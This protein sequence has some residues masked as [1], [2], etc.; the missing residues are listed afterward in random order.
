MTPPASLPLRHRESRVLALGLAA[1][2]LLVPA[3]VLPVLHTRIAGEV[4]TDTIYSGVLELWHTGLWPIAALVFI[5]SFLVPFAKLAGLAWLLLAAR[6]GPRNPRRLTQL[7]ALLDF[8]GRWSMLDV[9][10]AAF[11]AGLIQFGFLAA[12][13][14]RPGLVAFAAAVVLTM[15]ATHSFDPRLLWATPRHE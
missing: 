8:I 2:L 13:E 12:V 1:A 10:L 11:L 7:Y 5:A 9:F 6:R 3:N 15:L 4:R 14:P